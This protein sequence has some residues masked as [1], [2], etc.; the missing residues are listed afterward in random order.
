MTYRN[1]KFS[2]QEQY[3]SYEC[4]VW[5]CL[6]V[7]C[8]AAIKKHNNL[9]MYLK[10]EHFRTWISYW[11]AISVPNLIS[12]HKRWHLSLSIQLPNEKSWKFSHR[13]WV[14]MPWKAIYS[15]PVYP[16]RACTREPLSLTSKAKLKRLTKIAHIPTYVWRL[17]LY[18]HQLMLPNDLYVYVDDQ[19]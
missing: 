1:S 19:R 14:Y 9:C 12:Y 2:K 10:T 3:E 13:S 15:R 18:Y 6:A 17:P 16:S 11:T 7:H 8:N 4:Q 5:R